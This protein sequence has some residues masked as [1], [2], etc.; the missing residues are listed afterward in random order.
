MRWPTP[1]DT[2]SPNA[3]CNKYLGACSGSAQAPI[4]LMV[5]VPGQRSFKAELVGWD[6]YCLIFRLE[7]KRE[8]LM[9]KAPGTKIYPESGFPNTQGE[10][11]DGQRSDGETEKPSSND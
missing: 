3:A 1:K 5:E 2:G 4:K 9:F 6:A 7:D 11:T 10:S 8:V